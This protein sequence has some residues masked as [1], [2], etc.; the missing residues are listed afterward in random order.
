MR[1]ITQSLIEKLRQHFEQLP[2]PR[3]GSNTRLHLRPQDSDG[4]QDCEQKAAKRWLHQHAPVYSSLR[5]IFLDVALLPVSPG[6]QNYAFN[7]LP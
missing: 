6:G 5:L 1:P 7:Q 3:N 2:D 4:K